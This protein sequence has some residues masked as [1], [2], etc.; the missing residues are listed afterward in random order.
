MRGG[1]K[2]RERNSR[3]GKKSLFLCSKAMPA[4]MLEEARLAAET[5]EAV[6]GQA[7]REEEEEDPA[8]IEHPPSRSPIFRM[9]PTKGGDRRT[10]SDRTRSNVEPRRDIVAGADGIAVGAFV[11]DV[12]MDVV[13]VTVVVV[14]AIPFKT[15]T[16]RMAKRSRAKPGQRE[17]V[18][19]YEG[20]I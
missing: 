17:I 19:G 14:T 11:I 10:L 7:G 18:G 20:S 3:S 13:V 1:G 15:P 12:V 5:T 16:L 8:P 2:T 4:R 6:S 9:Q